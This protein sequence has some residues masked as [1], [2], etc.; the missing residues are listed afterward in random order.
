M[1]GRLP[2]HRYLKQ[3]C[4]LR[5][6]AQQWSRHA[7]LCR[8]ARLCGDSMILCDLLS[9]KTSHPSKGIFE[10]IIE[11]HY[12][13]TFRPFAWPISYAANPYG[14]QQHEPSRRSAKEHEPR[15]QISAHDPDSRRNVQHGSDKLFQEDIY[16]CWLQV[17]ISVPAPL[18]RLPR[19]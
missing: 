19:M 12:H 5:Q 14:E 10:Y 6:R 17:Q 11:L 1:N 2:F 9:S 16:L 8:V 15:Q 18:Y 3:S 4:L 7:D 13:V